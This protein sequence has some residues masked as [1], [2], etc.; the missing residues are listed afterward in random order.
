MRETPT[1]E[2]ICAWFDELSNWGR[3]GSGDLL[4]TLN[5]VTQRKRQQ[6]AALVRE[7]TS[8][9][10][11][12]DIRFHE[13]NLDDGWPE[14]RRFA[15]SLPGPEHYDPEYVGRAGA[16]EAVLLNCHGL[17]VTHLDGPAH[18]FF[19]PYPGRPLAGYNGLSPT[20]V[21]SREGVKKGAITL[22]GDG[23]VSRAVLLDIARL[24][25]VEW[26]DP[27]TKIFPEDLDEAEER[28]GIRA[29]SGDILCIRTG[30][31]GRKR[32]LGWNTDPATQAGPDGACLPWFRER[33]IAILACDTANDWVPSVKGRLDRPVHGIGIPAIGLWLLDGADYEKVSAE[34]SRLNRWEFFLALAPL[35]LGA[36][37]ASPVNPIA[38]L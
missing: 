9:S 26:L 28:Q 18:H 36:C 2:Q 33:D 37:T 15:R 19:R 7:G 12:L 14:P 11:G 23:I 20:E 34:C 6:A 35:K 27:G 31:P 4:G 22:A 30:H 1:D 32:A 13:P 24:R 3:W 21:S 8:I 10:C 16:S 5:L 38:V 25:G 17:G 29:E